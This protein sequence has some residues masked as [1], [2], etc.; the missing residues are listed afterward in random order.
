M[1][2]QRGQYVP[3]TTTVSDGLTLEPP[4]CVVTD[5]NN[6]MFGYFLLPYVGLNPNGAPIYSYPMFLA[7]GAALGTYTVTITFAT[8]IGG[9]ATVDQTFDV[10]AG[11]D[12]GGQVISLYSYDRPE[13]SFVL[14]QLSSGKLVQGRNPH[15]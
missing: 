2:Y 7:G 10:V 13:A 11:G 8:T 4:V 1:R 5:P 9:S 15:L 3:L 6:A 14:A 12:S